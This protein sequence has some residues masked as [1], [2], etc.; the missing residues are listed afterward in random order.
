M[1]S[2]IRG[3]L[4]FTLSRIIK[5]A[6]C[7]LVSTSG[8]LGVRCGSFS[9]LLRMCYIFLILHMSS[10]FGEYLV[11]YEYEIM[12]IWVSVIFSNVCCFLCFSRQFSWPGLNCTL[13]L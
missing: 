13:F 11:Y 4:C 3:I 7:L 2:F 10:Y 5:I 1:F 9:F 8:S 6:A 12:K